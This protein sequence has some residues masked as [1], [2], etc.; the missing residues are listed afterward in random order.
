[1][2]TIIAFLLLKISEIAAVALASVPVYFFGNWLN[3]YGHMGSTPWYA[4]VCI[5]WLVLGGGSCVLA[6]LF[7]FIY[8]NWEAA[9]KLS[10]ERNDR[11]D[12]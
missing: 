12:Q 11:S 7:I 2:R 8:A 4:D 9:K 10:A 1:M 6:L 3:K 5:G